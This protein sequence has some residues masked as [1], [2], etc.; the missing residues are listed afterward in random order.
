MKSCT[1]VTE[2]RVMAAVRRVEWAAACYR[3]EGHCP[4]R[5]H[6]AQRAGVR[7]S[8]KHPEVR[9]AIEQALQMLS[10]NAL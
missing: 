8:Q 4:F 2:T 9:E 7:Q 5:S 6:L 1:K 10:Q 3:Q